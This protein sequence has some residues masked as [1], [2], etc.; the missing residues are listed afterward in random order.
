MCSW[1]FF[2]VLIHWTRMALVIHRSCVTPTGGQIHDLWKIY[3]LLGQDLEPK[4]AQNTS[5][6]TLGWKRALRSL[7]GAVNPAL[8]SPPLTQVLHLQGF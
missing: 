4:Q 3:S 5:Q 7:S 8:S 2:L 1:E 6:N